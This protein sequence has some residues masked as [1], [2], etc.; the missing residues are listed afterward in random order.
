MSL[1]AHL[2]NLKNS[3]IKTGNNLRLPIEFLKININNSWLSFS[4]LEGIFTSPRGREAKLVLNDVLMDTGNESNYSLISAHYFDSFRKNIKECDFEFKS[5]TSTG[6]F[7]RR[8][9]ISVD[10]FKLRIK[11]TEFFTKIG[12]LFDA[13]ENW[14][15]TI[16]IGIKSIKQFMSAIFS[17][18]NTNYFYSSNY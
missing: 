11:N 14:L 17:V 4:I 3:S 2:K 12:F 9:A 10:I 5:L 15:N 8:T 1:L 13:S 7:R 18:E 6:G 16:N